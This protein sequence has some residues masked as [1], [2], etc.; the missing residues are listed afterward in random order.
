MDVTQLDT[1]VI[2]DICMNLDY[3]DLLNLI[4]SNPKFL[5]IC[6]GELLQW[7][8][9][10]EQLVYNPYSD[11]V[12]KF[13]LSEDNETNPL[14]L[15]F[16]NWAIQRYYTPLMNKETLFRLLQ[17]QYATLVRIMEAYGLPTSLIRPVTWNL[18]EEVIQLL[19]LNYVLWDGN[20]LYFYGEPQLDEEEWDKVVTNITYLFLTPEAEESF[21]TGRYD[22]LH[23]A[24][25]LSLKLDLKLGYI[26]DAILENSKAIWEEV[27]DPLIIR[28][29]DNDDYDVYSL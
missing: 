16:R 20:S 6:G 7:K 23:V 22:N 25:T 13:L 15:R 29:G 12:D 18:A 28:I 9:R 8:R 10:L 2:E 24:P 11:L 19:S 27:L 26:N 4:S 3:P 14:F 1:D 5:E 21:Q 17:D